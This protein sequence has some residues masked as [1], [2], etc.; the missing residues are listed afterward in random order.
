MREGPKAY[1]GMPIT[2]AAHAKIVFPF[3][4]PRALYIA[5]ANSGKPKPAIERKN[6]V[7]A[8][9]IEQAMLLQSRSNELTKYGGVYLPD[10]AY[11]V[12]ESMTYIWIPWKLR[13][14]PPP[15]MAM[16]M[17]GTIQWTFGRAPQPV[18]NNPIGSRMVPGNRQAVSPA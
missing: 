12:K 13:I 9:A 17:S 5:G 4:Y 14:M 15:T 2:I 18:M 7:E 6:V 8:S 3:P 16:P 11:N 1:A 10:A